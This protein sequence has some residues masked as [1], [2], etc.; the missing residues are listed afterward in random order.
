[1]ASRIMVSSS[2]TRMD[3]ATTVP[4]SADTWHQ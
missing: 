4:P 2:I 1:M 3:L